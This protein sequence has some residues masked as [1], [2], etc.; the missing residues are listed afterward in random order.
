MLSPTSGNSRVNNHIG[1]RLAWLSTW[2]SKHNKLYIFIKV[3]WIQIQNKNKIN[4]K[5][6]YIECF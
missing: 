1:K 2:G 5:L 3:G 6:L 4:Q